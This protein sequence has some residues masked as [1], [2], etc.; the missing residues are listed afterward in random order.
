MQMIIVPNVGVGS[1]KFGMTRE[2]VRRLFPDPPDVLEHK[3]SIDGIPLETFCVPDTNGFVQCEYKEPGVLQHF[4]LTKGTDPIFRA[5]HIFEMSYNDLVTWLKK[6]DSR[7]RM[8]NE[9][10]FLNLGVI[11]GEPIDPKANPAT[12]FGMFEPG[13]I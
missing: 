7:Y 8:D 4:D 1:L 12:F 10:I 2:E 3:Q 13:Y 5:K 11:I 9:I 6:L